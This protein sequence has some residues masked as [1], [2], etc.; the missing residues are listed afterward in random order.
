ME[1]K[2]VR[3]HPTAEVSELA[4]IGEG[5]SI[6]HQAQIRERVQIGR[7]CIIGKGVYVDFDV[8]MGDECKAQ[9]YVCIYHGVKIG[10]RV[11]LGPHCSF[12]NDLYPRAFVSDFKVS[13]TVVEDGASICTNA[14]IVC[15]NRIGEYSMVGAG[16][17]V[18]KDV[19][20]HTL[21]YGN[22]ARIMG[23]VC[24]MGHKMKREGPD[25]YICEI[26]KEDFIPRT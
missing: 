1:R 6:W 4:M 13:E 2:N 14:T 9:N 5:T 23:Y 24:K 15:G 19:P 17:V 16:A 7:K 8:V 10:N 22:P 3:I 18:T 11:F 26:C 25:H 20:P 21:V 12:T